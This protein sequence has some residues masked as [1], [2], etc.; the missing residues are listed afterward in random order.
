MLDLSTLNWL[1]IIVAGVAYFL[2]G[3]LWYTVLFA[4]PFQKY[5]G[6]IEDG[7]QPLDY[8]LTLVCDLAAALVLAIFVRLAGATTLEHGVAVGLAA[9]AGFAISNSFV[10]GIFNGVRKE[11]WLIE[12]GYTLVAYAVM[13][14]ILALWR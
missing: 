11:L 9:A 4:K 5:R 13:G 2:L 8:I 7:G 10:F 3:A 6:T 14:A 1:A 12:S